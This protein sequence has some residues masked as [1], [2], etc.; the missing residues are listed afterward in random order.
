MDESYANI[1]EIMGELIGQK[2]VD[3]TQH[4]EDYFQVHNRG[5]IDLMLDGGDVLRIYSLRGDEP[6]IVLNPDDEHEAEMFGEC[7]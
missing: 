7:E 1:R 3:I 6:W 5:F 2:V 4:D